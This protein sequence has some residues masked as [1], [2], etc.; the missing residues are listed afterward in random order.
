MPRAARPGVAFPAVVVGL[1][2]LLPFGYVFT[3]GGAALVPFDDYDVHA[4]IAARLAESGSLEVPHPLFHGL[5]IVARAVVPGA[6]LVLAALLVALAAQAALVA[7]TFAALRAVRPLPAAT[8]G[9]LA[10]LLA[11][12]EPV[13]FLSPEGRPAYFGYF[14]PN[15]WHNPTVVLLRPLALG[16][17]LAYTRATG[18]A[19]RRPPGGLLVLIAALTVASA[20]AKPSYVMCLLPAAGILWAAG[21]LRGER[22]LPRVFLAT[23][24]PGLLVLAAQAWFIAHSDFMDRATVRFAPLLALSCHVPDGLAVLAGKALMSVLF[25]ATVLLAYGRRAWQDPA[26]RLAWLVLGTGMAYAYLLAE[27]GPRLEDCNYL[28]GA[29]V[30]AFVL[31]VVSMRFLLAQGLGSRP[32]LVACAAAFAA[33]AVSGALYAWRL[34]TTHR[35]FW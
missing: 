28:W 21:W 15:V 20:L 16:L 34:V 29:Q 35:A 22:P 4:G 17:F 25:P 12:V 11:L 14:F 23:A 24:V 8:A 9:A 26:L 6:D 18:G 31:F 30:A 19:R 1:L 10:L 7:L 3:L 5:V 2:S 27:P 33:H 32:R 13:N